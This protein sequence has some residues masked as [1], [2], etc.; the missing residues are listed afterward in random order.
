MT[1]IDRKL[2]RTVA[3]VLRNMRLERLALFY[4]LHYP[5][6]L[7]RSSPMDIE[8]PGYPGIISGT[9]TKKNFW[10]E[11][12]EVMRRRNTFKTPCNQEL[13]ADDDLILEKK[14]ENA[15][16]RPPHWPVDANYPICNNKNAMNKTNVQP[17]DFGNPDFLKPFVEPCD[18]LQNV[19]FTTVIQSG[20]TEKNQ[21]CDDKHGHSFR[22]ERSR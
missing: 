19:M 21:S 10:I 6:Q 16:C 17:S 13:I 22:C 3:I 15:G 11:N 5:K 4:I 1:A 9:L 18:Q 7:I 12:L 8:L 20:P 14:L 2:V